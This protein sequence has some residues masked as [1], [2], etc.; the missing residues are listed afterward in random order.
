MA[1][2]TKMI[3]ALEA[4]NK[5]V[6]HEGFA[7]RM[8]DPDFA[9]KV[10]QQLATKHKVQDSTDF[11]NTYNPLV[12]ERDYTPD[13][14][15]DRV[16]SS[17][18]SSAELEQFYKENPDL[19]DEML[20]YAPSVPAVQANTEQPLAS[21]RGAGGDALTDI[22]R[23]LTGKGS[24]VETGVPMAGHYAYE[25]PGKTTALLGSTL[26]PLS[27]LGLAGAL[28][29]GMGG[30]AIDKAHFTTGEPSEYQTKKPTDNF[31]DIAGGG[32]TNALGHGAGWATSK[33][34]TYALANTAARDALIAKTI[35]GNK[36]ISAKNAENARLLEHLG[37]T[38]GAGGAGEGIGAPS[39]VRNK[40]GALIRAEQPDIVNAYKTLPSNTDDLAGLGRELEFNRVLREDAT[41][42]I[43][44]QAIK[45]AEQYNRTLDAVNARLAKIGKP[46]R[47]PVEVPKPIYK[48]AD[49]EIPD[50]E[51]AKRYV[52]LRTPLP[53]KEVPER[54][55]FNMLPNAIYSN[56]PNLIRDIPALSNNLLVSD[57]LAEYQGLASATA[58][59]GTGLTSQLLKSRIL[60]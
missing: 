52:E 32:I 26:M 38:G 3:S 60:K 27:W 39:Y 10:R 2:F 4:M 17:P 30:E 21:P 45:Q 50:W 7:D 29:L 56:T 15:S 8:T 36:A 54:V 13:T 24:I 9:E 48:T 12:A 40:I 33:G 37:I 57:L 49:V 44:N 28:G 16:Q 47:A 6:D 18:M 41:T 59:L 14:I 31:T 20:R 46:L 42:P 34:I 35:A 51:I 55:G 23:G 19:R 5:K 11:Y 43:N 1:D 22:W 53:L 58:N 25:N